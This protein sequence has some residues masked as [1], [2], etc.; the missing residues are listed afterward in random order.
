MPD[1][2]MGASR[3]SQ[4]FEG[5]CEQVAGGIAT[6]RAVLLRQSFQLLQL[7]FRQTQAQAP[8]QLRR[9]RGRGRDGDGK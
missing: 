4:G 5:L 7:G 2:G 1:R 9:P 8:F 6:G 3:R